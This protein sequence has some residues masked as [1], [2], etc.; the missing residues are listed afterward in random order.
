MRELFLSLTTYYGEIALVKKAY[1]GKSD[2]SRLARL[3]AMHYPHAIKSKCQKLKFW[4]Q[5]N[6]SFNKAYTLDSVRNRI[7]ACLGG[8]SSS[9]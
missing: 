4:R 5:T 8:T 2:P 6:G 1:S 7:I 9:C 3:V